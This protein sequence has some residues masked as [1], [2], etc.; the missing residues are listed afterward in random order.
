M[1]ISHPKFKA[2]VVQAAPAFLDLT[3]ASFR[4]P[5]VQRTLPVT[6][7]GPTSRAFC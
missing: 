7:R 6:I 3:S 4:S 5:R 1:G 2:A